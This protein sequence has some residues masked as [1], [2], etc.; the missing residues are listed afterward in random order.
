MADELLAGLNE[1]QRAAVLHT[2]GPLL[3]LAGAGSGKTR[4]ITRRVAHLLSKGVPAQQI[5]AVT[6]TNKAAGEM[7]QRI[8]TLAPGARV[9]V[10]TFH[11]FCAR[12]LRQHA[13]QVGLPKTFTI[14]DQS[15]RVRIL[16]SIIQEMDLEERD[17]SPG[18][19]EPIISRAKND[20]IS[21]RRFQEDALISDS[22]KLAEIY[23]RY[24]DQLLQLAAVDFD[25][26]LTFAVRLVKEHPE[27][28]AELDDR[29]R[30][31][32]VDEYQDTNLAQ[33]ALIRALS[34]DHPNLCVTGDPDQSIYGWRGANLNNIL[35][36]EKDYP[37]CRVIKLEKN[38]R[39]T[40]YILQAA[41]QLIRNNRRR[42]PKLLITDNPAGERVHVVTYENEVEE[43]IGV[44][45]RIQRMIE[46]GRFGP[47]DIAI[48]FRVS[49][50]TRGLETA[51]RAANIAYQVVG[52]VS[53]YERQEVK[54]LLAYLR[55]LLNPKD[56]MAFQRIVN[57]PPRGL[58]KVA[59]QHLSNRAEAEHCS[60]LE[61]ARKVDSFSEFK[62]K[63]ARALRE[64]VAMI[65]ELAE[66]PTMTPEIAL[67]DVLRVSGYREFL[68]SSEEAESEDRLM[69]L[70]EL[71]SAARDFES[72]NPGA[73]T[74]DFLEEMSLISSVD[75]LKEGS[76][77]VALMTMHA[78]KGLEFPV[79]FIIG[80]EQGILPHSR[81][82]ERDEDL[83]EE[84][85]LMFVGITRARQELYLSQARVREFR[86][87]RTA[88]MPSCFLTELPR[89][90]ISV[91]NQG[92]DRM[93][94]WERIRPV[95][96]SRT[97]SSPA[98]QSR[99]DRPTGFGLKSAAELSK[100]ASE[101]TATGSSLATD[102]YLT[103]MSV[104]HPQYGIGRII[105]LE[106]MGPTRK[107]RV[108]FTVG[109]ER[110]FILARSELRPLVKPKTTDGS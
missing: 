47:Q 49:A 89:D 74:T 16:K 18:R 44:V 82:R 59:M 83:E 21:P 51:F 42:K 15:D 38:Y 87:Q 17:F 85:R 33:Y 50:L 11:G 25:D 62:A 53:F 1:A 8:S 106:G 60:L 64:F 91:E 72:R 24:Q 27:T 48:F 100:T 107:G 99:G 70:D 109:G 84:R 19:V 105:S 79:V 52:G 57:Q 73:T 41:D 14:M 96:P 46:E 58:G 67:R 28:R 61:A 36:F 66:I 103:G 26:L 29:F 3:L 98:S 86:G 68:Q 30:F 71:I 32:Q 43:A 81:V 6:F 56:D 54:D 108:A 40:K 78:A 93:E 5:L 20:L 34:R 7:K 22:K 97:S 2:D 12:L 75:T 35:D 88:T 95:T 13:P 65:D 77:A 4:V 94:R 92:R 90:A 101:A 37:G 102:H 80:L 55:L 69:N 104:V 9:W 110:T 63:P 31:I 39:S 76:G 23:Q 45:G 10:G